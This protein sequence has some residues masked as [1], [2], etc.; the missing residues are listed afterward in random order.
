MDSLARAREL[1]ESIDFSKFAI[2]DKPDSYTMGDGK[3]RMT[4]IYKTDT[5]E[6][7]RGECEEGC[8]V[9][10]HTH[11]QLENILLT[12]GEAIITVAGSKHHLTPGATV[13]IPPGAI[14]YTDSDV[15]C[16]VLVARIPPV[17]GVY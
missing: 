1:Y 16:K 9:Q 14:H 10:P 3:M 5:V 12:E 11:R 7:L 4:V 13:S 17:E 2:V 6:V 15:G 8:R